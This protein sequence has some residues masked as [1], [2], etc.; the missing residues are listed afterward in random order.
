METVS[1]SNIIVNENYR[2]S[3]DKIFDSVHPDVIKIRNSTESDISKE[4]GEVDNIIP[5]QPPRTN[6]FETLTHLFKGNVGPGCFAMA[7]AAMNGGLILGPVLTLVLGIICVHAQHILLN[8]SSKMRIQYQMSSKPDYAET[9]ELC[10]LNSNNERWR[11]WAPY[12]KKLCNIFICI[13]QLGIC[14]IYYLFITTNMKQV[15]D[16][17]GLVIDLPVLMSFILIPMWLSALITNLKY[18]APCSGI[19]NLCMIT[20]LVISYYYSV[21]NLPPITDRHFLPPSINRLPLFFGTA[22]FAFEGIALV[23]PLQ[24]AMKK[25][26]NFS[27]PLGVLN[28]GMS[29]V[30]TIFITFGFVGYWKYGDDTEASLTLN[31]PTDEILAQC[32][33][34]A[35]AS[36]VMLGYAIQFFVAIQVMYPSIRSTIP[37]A[38]HHPFFGELLFRSFMVLITFAIAQLVPNLSLLLSLFGS[39]CSTVLALVLPPIIEIILNSNDENGVGWIVILK[40]SS[41]LIIAFLGFLTEQRKLIIDDDNWKSIRK[42]DVTAHSLVAKRKFDLEAHESKNDQHMTSYMETLTHLFKGNMGPGCFAMADAVMNGGLLLGPILILFFGVV[43]V[44]AQHIL[45]NCSAKMKHKYQLLCKP[46]YAETVGLCFLSSNNEK[47]RKYASTM[48]TVCNTFICI[49]QL[50]ICCIYFLFI[51]TNLKQ[52]LD[53][54]NFQVSLT[55]MM[56][57]VLIPI[58][59][60]AL[61]TNLKF[62]APCSGIANVCMVLGLVISYFYSAQD[63]P[64]I[65]ERY[66]IPPNMK[67]LPLFFGT[68]IFAFEGIALVLP[69]QN[70]MRKPRNFSKPLG[71]LNVGMFY[72]IAIF[73]SFGA[74]GYWKYGDDTQASLTLNLPTDDILAQCV[75]IAIA[76]GVML[77]YAIQFYI[78]INVMYPSIMRKFRFTDR[79]PY[80]GE[81]L[82]RSFMVIITFAIA[83]LVPNLSLLL[84]LIGALCST[85]LALVLPPIIEFI[86]LSNEE[87]GVT[88]TLLVKNY[89]ILIISLIGVITGGYESLSQLQEEGRLVE[90]ENSGKSETKYFNL[91]LSKG[92]VDKL[93]VKPIAELRNAKLE[94]NIE[95]INENEINPKHQTSYMETLTHLFKGNVGP[96]CFALAEAVKNSGL[97]LGPIL[98]VALGVICVHAQHIL[99]ECSVKM[100]DKYGLERRPDYAETVELCF[101][102]SNKKRWRKYATKM[103]MICNLFICITQLGFCCVYYLFISTNIKQ[104]LDHY[105]FYF[106]LPVLITI[107]LIPIWLSAMITNLKYLAPCSG[108]A[109]VCMILGLVICYFYSVQD[110]PPISERNLITPNINQLPLFFGTAIFAFEGI[111]LVL[112]LQNAMKKPRNFSRSLGVLNVGMVIVIAIFM[113]FGAFGY[114]KYGDKTEASLT[115]NLPADEILAQCV[116]LAIATGVMLGYAIQFFVPIQIMYP[117]IRKKFTFADRHPYVGELLF[118]SFMVL[119]TFIIAQLVPNLGLLL[120]LIGAVCSTVIALVLPPL[121]EF[122]LLANEDEGLSFI[123]ISKNLVIL[124]IALLGFWTGITNVKNKKDIESQTSNGQPLTTYM[125]TLMHLF[126]ANVGT[127]CFAMADAVKN[128]GLI[129]GP[130]LILV[131]GVIC[132]HAQ[133]MLINCSVKMKDKYQ[134]TNRPDYAET[135]ELCFLSST[136]KTWRKLAPSMKFICNVIICV[137]QLGF[138]CVYYLFVGTNVKQILDYYNFY[139]D[140]PLLFAFALIPIWLSALITNLKYLAPCSGF[141]NICMILGLVISYYYSVQDLPPITERRFIPENI[142]QLPLFFGTALFAFEGISL[143][144][145]LQNAMK[146]PEKFSRPLGVLNVGM[147]IISTILISFGTVGYW[148]YGEETEASLSLNLPIDELL[149][150]CVKLAIATGVMLG[151]AIQFFVPMQIMYPAIRNNFVFADRHPMF[152]EL[153]FRSFMVLI[154]FAIAQ[155]IPNLGLLL[156]LIGAVCSTVLALVLPPIVEFIILSCEENGIKWKIFSLLKVVV[157]MK[158]SSNEFNSSSKESEEENKEHVKEI[159]HKTS[160]LEALIHFFKAGVGPGCFAIA[161]AMSNTG[162]ALGICLTIFLSLVCLYEQHVLLK[163][164]NN[165]KRYFNMEQRPDYAQTFEWSLQANV[166]WKKHSVVMRRIV[167]IFLILTQLGFCSVYILFIGNN[168]RNFL[169]YFGYEFNVRIVIMLTFIPVC[170]PALI[171]NLKFLAPFSGL[172]SVCMLTGVGI[173]LYY[174]F[175]DLPD[176]S[177]RSQAVFSWTKL[178]LFFGTVIYLFEGIGLV[179]PL[180][181]SMKKPSNFSRPLGALNVGVAMQTTLFLTLGVFGYWKYGDETESSLTLNLP[182]DEWLAQAVLLILSIGVILGYAIQFFIPMQIMFP[183]VQRVIKP[184]KHHPLIGEI[185]FRAF[186]VLVTYGVALVV[187]NLGLLISLIG[188]VCSNSLALLFPVLIEYLVV[189]RDNKSMTGIFMAKNG[190]ILFMALVG[191]ASVKKATTPKSKLSKRDKIRVSYKGYE[192]LHADQPPTSYMETLMHLFKGNVGT[193]CYAMAEATKNGGLILGPVLT[194]IIAIINVHAQHVLLNCAEIL[195]D[196]ENLEFSPDYAET[197]YLCFANSTDDGWKKWAPRMKSICNIFICFT[198]LG[199][200]SVYFL[201]V[202]EHLKQVFDFYGYELDVQ[203]WIVILLVPILLTAVIRTLK[204]LAIISTIANV[205]MILGIFLTIGYAATDLPPISDRDLIAD[206]MRLPLFFGT[207]LY[208]FEGIA[209]VLPLKNAMNKPENFTRPLGVLNIGM[210]LVTICF[211]FIGFV[212]YWHY[213]E[214]TNASLTL[215]LPIDDVLA[216][217]IKM[218]IAL[219]VLMTYGIQFFVAIQIMFAPIYKNIN[220]VERHPVISEMILRLLVVLITFTVAQGIPHLSLLLSLIGSVCCAVLAFVLPAIAE[221]ILLHNNY[222]GIGWCCWLK[223]SIILLIAFCGFILGGG[224]SIKAIYEA[225]MKDFQK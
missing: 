211:V 53:F 183:S 88:W 42:I 172:A 155:V 4:K 182:T 128:S 83:Q 146:K 212:G 44:H 59:L 30:T 135:V 100:R 137:T 157:K 206:Y 176:I 167:N 79:H 143:V 222:G 162:I 9:V 209:L 225:I 217:V 18:L 145:P 193:G 152:S 133:H 220:C 95:F 224:L 168:M 11:K 149:A 74:V 126:K 92:K 144:L 105:H 32:V 22:I 49:T 99:L 48:K 7:D 28:V 207:V 154:T 21:Q 25:Q 115:L 20:G 102:S 94:D 164:A 195:R 60:S 165:V 203:L 118:R 68:A 78:A 65:N 63:L 33:K 210:V 35:I 185:I 175:Q 186:M 208:S 24:N 12:M 202:G 96:G 189:T 15:L 23:L 150:Q 197:L 64:P 110:L 31:L 213:G 6:Y 19:A 181:N 27:K 171:T 215:N 187:P 90:N 142:N 138:C 204:I 13:T 153:L 54:Y 81:L 66:F 120:S 72:V 43:C 163:C 199:Y 156:S 56:T 93:D 97:L 122:I 37:F 188:A 3:Q 34:V 82:F 57:I 119:I 38:S 177:E 107:A 87:E 5:N 86:I 61:I 223:N 173:T 10:F 174:V 106:S 131:L 108:I 114:W 80:I 201:F 219:A 180:K 14:C 70:A 192:E 198:Q 73:I 8:C 113:S 161:E 141:A 103:K 45:L 134:M 170:L 159:K 191:F 116:K 51:G 52:V 179:L 50:G 184:A 190:F 158:E 62:L 75:K 123:V 111:A 41:I 55:M 214:S 129:L 98:I 140:L 40:N 121:I 36:G 71:V 132:V 169:I 200:C 127:G 151:Y 29:I 26:R 147:V 104:V 91:D 47:Y 1:G 130:I 148:K 205:F 216:Q 125:E 69:L 196:Q 84:S 221:L 85:S 76:L 194:I 58:W 77:G 218:M 39:V 17:Y 101:L 46:D 117:A 139:V 67:Q 124:I 136:N 160:Y 112:P 2:T 16:H 178:P 109:N 166:K 89:S